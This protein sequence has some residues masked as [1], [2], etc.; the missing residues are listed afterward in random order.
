MKRVMLAP[1][2]KSR[3]RYPFPAFV[4]PPRFRFPPLGF[5]LGINNDHGNA[6]VLISILGCRLW[7]NPMA[8]DH[9]P[10]FQPITSK[11]LASNSRLM[12]SSV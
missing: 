1:S 4:M 6:T 10:L 11:P 9:V 2:I 8:A 3:L 5:S 12:S 7:A